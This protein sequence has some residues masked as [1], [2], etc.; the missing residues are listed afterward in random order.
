MEFCRTD[1]ALLI[2]LGERTNAAVG[3]T[4]R[5]QNGSSFRRADNYVGVN[6]RS[7][8]PHYSSG[9]RFRWSSPL[10]RDRATWWI[11]SLSRVGSA[12]SIVS[13][14]CSATSLLSCHV[15]CHRCV[16]SVPV[17][18][19]RGCVLVASRRR[20]SSDYSLPWSVADPGCDGSLGQYN[21]SHPF[22]LSSGPL[23]QKTNDK[24]I[25]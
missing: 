11:G 21:T 24:F 16:V 13:S 8:S 23:A 7:F 19:V 5:D 2:D 10:V 18:C 22:L 17:L 20:C 15:K 4:A 12:G 6:C 1:G 3:V 14:C 9:L 25:G